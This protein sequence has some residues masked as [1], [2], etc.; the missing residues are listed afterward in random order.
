MTIFPCSRCGEVPE[1]IPVKTPAQ[2]QPAARIVH[3]CPKGRVQAYRFTNLSSAE[4]SLGV[5]YLWN[6]ANARDNPAWW[7]ERDDYLHTL[8][9]VGRRDCDA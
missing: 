9:K 7:P 8:C 6:E 4:S 3:H 5:I 2:P 1:V